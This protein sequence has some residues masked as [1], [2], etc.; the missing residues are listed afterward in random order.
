MMAIYFLRDDE[1]GAARGWLEGYGL[2]E[3]AMQDSQ[4]SEERGWI[5][6]ARSGFLACQPQIAPNGYTVQSNGMQERL[7]ASTR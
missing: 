1:G 2:R 3:E 5:F 4:L 6:V 7:A